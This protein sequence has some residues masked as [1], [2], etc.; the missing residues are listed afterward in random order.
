MNLEFLAV[1]GLIKFR[2][3]LCIYLKLFLTSFSV[4]NSEENFCNNL[5]NLNKYCVINSTEFQTEISV[6]SAFSYLL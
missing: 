3:C 5:N 2:L 1:I 6:S 4:K